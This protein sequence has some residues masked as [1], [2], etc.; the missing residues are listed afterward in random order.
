MQA[1]HTY[2]T[3]A[4]LQKVWAVRAIGVCIAMAL[5]VLSAP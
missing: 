2:T 3:P 1:N 5:L 4:K